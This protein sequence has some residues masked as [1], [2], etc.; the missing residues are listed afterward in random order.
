ME[1]QHV[2]IHRGIGVRRV[3]DLE[4]GA[5]ARIGGNGA[6]I[7]LYGTEGLWGM[8]LAEIPPAEALRPERHLYEEVVFVVEG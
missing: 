2:P 3:Q 8:Y 6:F 4:L 5:W 1:A 7:Q